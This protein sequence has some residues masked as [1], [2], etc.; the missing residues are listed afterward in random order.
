MSDSLDDFFQGGGPPPEEVAPDRLPAIRR[1]ARIGAVL[2][3]AGPFCFTGVP[4]AAV[5][6]WAWYRA[7]EELERVEAGT[8]PAERADAVRA[9]RRAAFRG[10]VLSG[11]ML[12]LQL[13]LFGM[14]AYDTL[15][16]AFLTGLGTILQLSGAPVPPGLAPPIP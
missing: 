5:A 1:L 4:G 12:T 7:D 10:V 11:G 14:G 15:A 3:V 6:L 9:T 13:V 16:D 2:S 8:V